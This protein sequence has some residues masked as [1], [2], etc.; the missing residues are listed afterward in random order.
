MKR[1]TLTVSYSQPRFGTIAMQSGA[2]AAGDSGD[3][4][5]TSGAAS[6]GS[7]GSVTLA[8]GAGDTSTG[9]ALSVAAGS[10]SAADGSGG[11][12]SFAPPRA[13]AMAASAP[14]PDDEPVM[15]AT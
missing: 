15:M 2:S 13:M 8:V 12:L 5:I 4:S 1:K 6:G 7:G 11:A 10:S 3:V 9:G 14:M